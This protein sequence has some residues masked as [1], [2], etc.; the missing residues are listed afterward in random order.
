MGMLPSPPR[1]LSIVKAVKEED[2]LLHSVKEENVDDHPDAS[3]YPSVDLE[4][5]DS[6]AS[7]EVE[8]E[9][10]YEARLNVEEEE[11]KGREAV[12]LVSDPVT[13]FNKFDEL[14]TQVQLYSE[15]ILEKVLEGY[16]N[17]SS[18]YN[19]TLT[20]EEMWAKE[21]AELVPL[22]SGGMLRP[23]QIE[24]V[25]WLMSLWCNGLNGILADQMSLG[26]TIQTIGFL[27]H[28]KGNGLHG[29]YMIIAPVLTLS[30]WVDEISRLVP[31]MACLIYY[32]DKLARSEIRRKLMPK[33]GG[34]DFPIIVTSYEMAMSDAKIL[35]QYRWKYIVFDEGH[36][37]NNLECEL[38]RKLR[39]LP[40]DNGLLLT[41]TPFQ[42]NL[43]ELWSLLNFAMPDIFSSHQELESWFD[44]IEKRGE[45]QE[46]TIVNRRVLVSKLHTALDPFLLQVED[47]MCYKAKAVKNWN[48]IHLSEDHT[49]RDGVRSVG[50]N[51]KGAAA[52]VSSENGGEGTPNMPSTRLGLEGNKAKRPRTDDALLSLLGE[53]NGT[54][55]ASLRPAE[56]VQVPK[57][58]SPAEILEALREIPD[59]ARADLLRAYS[60]LIRDDRQF[61]SLVALPM[62]MRKDWLLMEVGNK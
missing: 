1:Q 23:Y 42:N 57:A 33:T 36:Q 9:Q 3:S 59:L 55:Q 22:V 38:S 14:L 58:T 46:Q 41:G 35:A 47:S 6:D 43:A 61:R 56:P 20:E 32:G 29:P 28:L 7:M 25:K 19:A 15:F 21:Q 2:Q 27:A 50:Q 17:Y 48:A 12:R 39:R 18:A 4:A 45:G 54:V 30:N 13:K 53:T 62:D 5:E 52:E 26:N 11:A 16:S 60:S 8:E 24:G 51:C 44:L 37:L 10:P 34:P 31:S 49:K 40:M